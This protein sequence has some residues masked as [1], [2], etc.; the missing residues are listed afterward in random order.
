MAD[1]E[2][3]YELLKTPEQTVILKGKAGYCALKEK[4]DS[5]SKFNTNKVW[6][7]SL[8][9]PKLAS[10][11]ELSKYG[12]KYDPNTELAKHILDK[13]KHGTF[14]YGP[15]SPNAGHTGWSM[16][17]GANP[18]QLPARIMDMKTKDVKPAP[19]ALKGELRSGQD[20][21]VFIRTY[22]YNFNGKTGISFSIEAVGLPDLSKAQFIGGGSST[23]N[24]MSMF[25][26]GSATSAPADDSASADDTDTKSAP[27]SDS[28]DDAS[29]TNE[30]D[31]DD[32]FS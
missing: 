29:E 27:A 3:L 8:V 2:N 22:E 31:I 23:E 18:K 25:G 6:S 13:A 17:W 15:K 30:E 14:D 32:L 21:F 12:L 28:A 19:E 24:F 4:Q 11:D 10:L 26:D 16:E 7:V 9:D 20:I 1:T 5:T